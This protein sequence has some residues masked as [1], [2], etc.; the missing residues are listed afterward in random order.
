[1]PRK[2]KVRRNQRSKRVQRTRNK[3]TKRLTK[4]G[5]TNV[6]K[7]S[8][9]RKNRKRI[10]KRKSNLYRQY[11]GMEAET[12]PRDF[13]PAIR[14]HRPDLPDGWIYVTQAGEPDRPGGGSGENFYVYE[15]TGVSLWNPPT[16]EQVD[17]EE[18]RFEQSQLVS[19]AERGN[20]NPQSEADYQEWLAITKDERHRANLARKHYKSLHRQHQ[21]LSLPDTISALE[22]H[23][24]G[25]MS[26]PKDL[27][28]AVMTGPYPDRAELLR[29][30]ILNEVVPAAVPIP[31]EAEKEAERHRNLVAATAA[32]R[33]RQDAAAADR[34]DADRLWWADRLDRERAG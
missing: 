14:H 24:R 2:S 32:M 12:K 30:L 19:L 16:D 17:I 9:R 4:R 33:G 31:T 20:S 13:V 28:D 34:R 11:G 15:P 3:N 6:R 7:N 26:V 27:V 10:S 23:A 8:K 21:T 25:S 18:I 29:Y 22:I 1:M 5:R